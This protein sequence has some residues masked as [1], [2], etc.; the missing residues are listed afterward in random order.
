MT[1]TELNALA[2]LVKAHSV[3]ADAENIHATTN[4]YLPTMN[5][6]YGTNELQEEL[7]KRGILK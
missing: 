2:A 1:D 3:V 6:V 5:L 4:G 7:E